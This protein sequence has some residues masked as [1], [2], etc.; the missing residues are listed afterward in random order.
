MLI[1]GGHAVRYGE[2]EGEH[3]FAAWREALPGAMRWA[4]PRKQ[5]SKPK[6]GDL[7]TNGH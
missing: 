6:A 4:L 5:A 1:A 3:D 7:T 2:F